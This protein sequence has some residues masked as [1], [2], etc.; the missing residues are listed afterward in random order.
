MKSRKDSGK[1][2]RDESDEFEKA[3][4]MCEE[5]DPDLTCG[6]TDEE[7]TYRFREAVRIENEIKRIKELPISKYDFEKMH[8]I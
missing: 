3:E 8:R 7:L 6:L 1:K 5:N 4:D 2:F